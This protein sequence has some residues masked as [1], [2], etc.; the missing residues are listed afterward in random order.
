MYKNLQWQIQTSNL[1]SGSG[2]HGA[3]V[4]V[5]SGSKIDPKTVTWSIGGASVVFS[6]LAYF[7]GLVPLALGASIAVFSLIFGLTVYFSKKKD[8]KENQPIPRI[9]PIP[10]KR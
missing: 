6:I 7:I 2:I 10:Q 1:S 8:E 9:P 4:T 3:Q 5:Y